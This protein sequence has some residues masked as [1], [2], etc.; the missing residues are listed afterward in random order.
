[1]ARF[2][3]TTV[4]S[5]YEAYS[6][7]ADSPAHARQ[8]VRDEKTRALLAEHAVEAGYGDDFAIIAV[9]PAERETNTR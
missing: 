5:A 4:V 2:V 6:V 9:N 1:M 8:L 7:E 3:V